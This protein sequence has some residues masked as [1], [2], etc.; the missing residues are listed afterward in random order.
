[1]TTELKTKLDN[2]VGK[3]FNY[4]GKNI[5]IEKYKE[6]NGINVVIF[7]PQPINLLIPEAQ[8]FFDNLF[9]P[10]VKEKTEVQVLVP[11]QQLVTFEPTKEN[12]KIKETLLETLEKI[13]TDPSFLPQA[14]AICEVVSQMVAVQ[15]NEIQML[16]II[17][18]F[19]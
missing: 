17:N 19:K 13:K 14:S 1:M 8:N 15:K 6:V 10:T 12:T 18:K 2:I 5:T 4:R 11:K 9:E 16:S 7:C 3:T